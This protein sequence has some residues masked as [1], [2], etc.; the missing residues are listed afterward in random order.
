MSKVSQ[1]VT[2]YLTVEQGYDLICL[3]EAISRR[4]YTS[5]DSLLAVALVDET[6]AQY[7]VGCVN[8]LSNQ[9]VRDFD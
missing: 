2:R 3:L 7:L 4:T 9:G 5:V 6:A 8:R 1:F